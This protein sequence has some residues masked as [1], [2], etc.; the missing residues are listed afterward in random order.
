[1]G[2]RIT[3]DDFK[4]ADY[5]RFSEKLRDGLAILAQLLSRPGFGQG[6]PS[7][8][9]ELEMFLMDAAGDPASVSEPLLAT[10]ND[11]RFTPELD[12]FN[13]EYNARPLALGGSCL[14][15]LE[16]DLRRGVV[17]AEA[18]AAAH[19]ARVAL[20]GILPTLRHRHFEPDAM[21]N[22]PRYRALARGLR[23]AR[24]SE[25][26]HLRI[27]GEDPLEL[28]WPH[29]TVEGAN[30]SLQL[31]LR[32][33]PTQFTA[34]YNAAQL[35]TAPILAASGNSPLFLGHRLWEETRVA[36]F[37]QAVD[38]RLDHGLA[39]QAP[40]VGFGE[41]WLRHGAGELF[42]QTVRTHAPLL[43]VVGELD[44]RDAMSRGDLPALQELRLHSSTVWTWNRPVYDPSG[45]L[46]I[47]LRALPAGPSVVDMVANAAFLLGL[48]L[49]LAPQMDALSDLPFD[50]AHANFYR[51]A[52][53]GLGARLHWPTPSGVELLPAPTLLRRL[54]PLAER[55]LVDAG[56]DA[57]AARHY[58]RVLE[59]RVA[60]GT[61]GAQWQR[62][63]LRQLREHL[64]RREALQNLT[65]E[66]MAHFWSGEPVS[67][68]PL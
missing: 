39:R 30:T 63:R 5:A 61:T 38:V 56:V 28:R 49:A 17:Q 44:D 32:V 46:R 55:G 22:L 15:E 60:S 23:R 35:A 65:L 18:A 53:H 13:L 3:S 62:A 21:S 19:G 47:E 57:R 24:N 14:D 16:E 48:T 37:K 40:R 43:P 34:V 68:G 58:R 6:P 20:M 33:A 41:G 8:G 27:D 67:H 59:A 9:A 64:T 25:S 26:F 52:Q 7:I 31:H 50:R 11:A 2:I 66:Y 1:L 36:L 42:E 12:R 45:H 54:L 10:L 4:E 29:V 51:A